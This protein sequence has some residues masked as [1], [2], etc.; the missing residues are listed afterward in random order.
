GLALTITYPQAGN[1]GGGGFMLIHHQGE[2][3]FLDYRETAPRKIR[4]QDLVDPEG[5]LSN[6]S[7]LGAMSVGVPG[8]IAGFGAALERFG[9]WKWDRIAALMIPIAKAG[10]WLTTRQATLLE[11]Y[12][13]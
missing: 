5:R 12:K 2:M 4:P 1:I 6:R 13:D 10:V 7:V 3:H 8:T 11:L 9:T